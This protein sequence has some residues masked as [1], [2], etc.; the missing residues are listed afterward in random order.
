MI[1]LIQL[2]ECQV[3]NICVRTSCQRHGYGRKLLLHVIDCCKQGHVK[4]IL[5]EVRCSNQI[6]MHCYRS[7]GLEKVAVR[8]DY[9]SLGD[10]REDAF[11]FN[12]IL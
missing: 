10:G 2:D 6:A 9:Y 11:I 3:L 1:V 4:K 12:L 8:R 7:V 5:L